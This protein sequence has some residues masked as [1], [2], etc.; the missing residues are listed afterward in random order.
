MKVFNL[1]GMWGERSF[2]NEKGCVAAECFFCSLHKLDIKLWRNM[3]GSKFFILG[4][5]F[6]FVNENRMKFRDKRACEV[7]IG[8]MKEQKL[9]F[10]CDL[11]QRILWGKGVCFRMEWRVKRL[12]H[13]NWI[14]W[15]C[16]Q[17][18][19]G[20]KKAMQM[21]EKGQ[22]KVKSSILW[23]SLEFNSFKREISLNF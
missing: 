23:E 22:K 9:N 10:I 21:L 15:K 5:F 13:W 2:P 16:P 3:K 12:G 17:E 11:F 19:E 20:K 18:F 7:K 14:I 1:L 6:S 8:L 4:F